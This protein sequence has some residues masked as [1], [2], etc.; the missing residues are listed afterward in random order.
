M[1]KPPLG[2]ERMAAWIAANCAFA[3]RTYQ[4]GDKM[5]GIMSMFSPQ[6]KAWIIKNPDMAIR[7]LE[8]KYRQ[9]ASMGGAMGHPLTQQDVAM[10]LKSVDDSIFPGQGAVL[11]T[12]QNVQDLLMIVKQTQPANPVGRPAQPGQ[13]QVA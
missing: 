13:A 3:A 10:D 12:P 5:A 1:S 2:S 4:L 8:Q 6:E 11:N 9:R 7:A